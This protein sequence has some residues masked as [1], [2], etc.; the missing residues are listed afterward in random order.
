ML[1]KPPRNAVPIVVYDETNE[2]VDVTDNK[3]N[4]AAYTP[5]LAE[6]Y[7]LYRKH[8]TTPGD[9]TNL[10]S[11]TNTTASI[12]NSYDY[13]IYLKKIHILITTLG[14]LRI[15]GWGSRTTGFT[16]GLDICFSDI[17]GNDSSITPEKIQNGLGIIKYFV[18][19][20]IFGANWTAG[21]RDSLFGSYKLDEPQKI[22]PGTKLIAINFSAEDYATNVAELEIFVDYYSKA[23]L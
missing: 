6:K 3:L 11:L 18:V 22:E 9:S 13:P 16:T 7:S 5:F 8:V 1:P 15:D 14:N 4:T 2:P 23:P 19:R 10:K 21:F 17:N 20:D 12:I